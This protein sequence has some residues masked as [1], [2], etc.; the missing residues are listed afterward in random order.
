MQFVD[1]GEL[2]SILRALRGDTEGR[3][4]EVLSSIRRPFLQQSVSNR[5]TVRQR[6]SV[7][8]AHPNI[9]SWLIPL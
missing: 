1:A 4:A 8:L 3:D 9:I 2:G 6:V 5:R 7:A